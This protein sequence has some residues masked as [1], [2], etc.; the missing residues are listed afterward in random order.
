MEARTSDGPWACTGTAGTRR[1]C[2]NLL[3]GFYNDLME[4]KRVPG[5]Q[6]AK[7]PVEDL[8]EKAREQL[9][10]EYD[11]SKTPFIEKLA[12]VKR[13]YDILHPPLTIM[14]AVGA[15]AG[16]RPGEARALRAEN[17]WFDRHLIHVCESVRNSRLGP[18]KNGKARD[19]L[20]LDS[21][22]PILERWVAE[23]GGTGL[24]FR[25]SSKRGGRPGK[26]PTYIQEHTMKRHLVAA[27]RSCK[28]P[29]ITWYEATR[30]T[31]ASQWVLEGKPIG[32]LA[33]MMGHS[34]TE[35]TE[36]YAH[37]RADLFPAEDRQALAI[38]LDGHAI[39]HGYKM[40][41]T[42]TISARNGKEIAT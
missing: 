13:V 33:K 14:Y 27:L 21:L 29:E 20:I 41:T 9:R 1:H 15:L 3:S 28:L 36:R 17:V 40:V 30:H 35:V 5:L 2:V 22:R 23:M 11:W 19:V 31:F 32:R 34:E 8:P 18:P 37:L 38:D 16:L 26:P 7:N 39:P 12:D 42:R 6:I 25:P 10:S 24:L 4:Y